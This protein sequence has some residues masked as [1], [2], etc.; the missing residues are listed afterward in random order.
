M[1]YFKDPSNKNIKFLRTKVRNLKKPLEKSGIKYEQIYKSIQHLSSS[2]AILDVH[3]NK[4]FKSLIKKVSKSILI[5]FKKYQALHNDTKIALLNEFIRKLK[6]NYYDIRSK[7]VDNLIK[8]I[9]KKDFK[10][11]TLGGCI[12]F[13]N[14]QNLCLKVEKL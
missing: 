4:I 10:K 3:F 2:K 11:T 6:K 9:D 5:D 13:K 12:F 1:V 14:G 8:N 7:K